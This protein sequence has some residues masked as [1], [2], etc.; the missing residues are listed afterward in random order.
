MREA[1]GV[2]CFITILLAAG[3]GAHVSP[4]PVFPPRCPP[5]CTG[6]P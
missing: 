5:I 6:A 4:T 2:L 1:V 3:Y